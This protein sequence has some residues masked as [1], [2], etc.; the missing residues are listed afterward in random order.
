MFHFFPPLYWP[1]LYVNGATTMTEAR[2][3]FWTTKIGSKTATKVPKLCSLPSTSEVF[4][5]N[6]KRAHFQCA[7]WRKVL[8]ESPNL[9]P[10]EY[11]WCKDEETKSLQPV[12]LP[13][14]KLPA[15]DY[16]LKLVCCSC[17]SERPRHSSR[18]GCVAAHLACTAF[19]QCQ[20]SSICKSELT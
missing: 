3:K 16:I 20:G 8:Q 2:I 14:S 13:P 9:D 1:I 6:V 12:P 5:E 4:E 19:C 18:R 11:G 17:G 7:T 15:P 10:T